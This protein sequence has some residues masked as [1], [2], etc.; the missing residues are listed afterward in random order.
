MKSSEFKK[1]VK[2]IVKE[3][4]K[5]EVKDIITEAIMLANTN[6]TSTQTNTKQSFVNENTQSP[7]EVYKQ[8][9]MSQFSPNGD[10]NIGVNSNDT[11]TYIPRAVDP[12]NGSLP[13]GNVGLDQI[14][15]LMSGK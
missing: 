1:V 8:M 13:E 12:A 11:N 10:N 7:S 9:M 3:A 15:N 4:I 6:N 14:M 5:E 2:Q